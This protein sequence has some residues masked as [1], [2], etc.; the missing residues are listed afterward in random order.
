MQI[1]TMK[2][3]YMPIRMAKKKRSMTIP[4]IVKDTDQMDCLQTTIEGKMV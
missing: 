2:D 4:S 1:K 3:K